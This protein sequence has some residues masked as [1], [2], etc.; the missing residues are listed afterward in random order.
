MVS[1]SSWS[2]FYQF[3]Y[4]SFHA[5]SGNTVLFP[6]RRCEDEDYSEFYR[7]AVN[8]AGKTVKVPNVP[9]TFCNVDGFQNKPRTSHFPGS[10]I[11]LFTMQ[12]RTRVEA[13]ARSNSPYFIAIVV[14]Q[15]INLMICKTRL[16]S[17]FEN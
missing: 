4:D 12:T 7:T 3:S 16:R 15:C 2:L 10:L 8:D 14:V 9:P 11:S 1:N 5:I 6:S 17:L 13:L